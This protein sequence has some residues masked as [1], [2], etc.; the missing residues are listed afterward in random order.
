MTLSLDHIVIAVS[1]LENTLAD[2]AAL[3]FNPIKGGEHANGI[4]H[5]NLVIFEDG[6]YLELI[7]WKRP[8]PGD[9]WSDIY[10]REGEGLVDHAL[11]P[12]DIEA[13][14]KAAQ[15]RGL[16]IRDPIPGGRNRPDGERLEWK[17]ARSPK[18]DV[19]F[20]CG[21]VTPRRLRVQE[22]AA[23]RKQPNGVTGVAEVT[24]AV[25]D[26]DASAKRY[27]ALLGQEPPAP[28]Q[29]IEVLETPSVVALL[30]LGGGTRI[31]L[32]SPIASGPLE[33]ILAQRGE[34]AVSVL[35]R[36]GAKAELDLART[37][38]A[39]MSTGG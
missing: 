35:F 14:V 37:H 3:G 9:R 25:R 26:A 33:A 12:D 6:A 2:Y 16:D 38:G 17:T 29:T 7:A 24:I 27:A 5:N 4:T 34:G 15:A 1:N 10:H 18:P 19:P 13:V 30:T 39:R 21:D 11:L 28:A 8:N 23:I 20:L 22:D 31:R 36:G 32:A